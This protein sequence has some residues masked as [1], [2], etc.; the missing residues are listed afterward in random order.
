LT[1]KIVFITGSSRGIGRGIAEAFLREGASVIL[2]GRDPDRLDKT[3][4]MLSSTWGADRVSAIA[5]NV[6]DEKE[7]RGIAAKIADAHGGLDVLVCNA[8]GAGSPPVLKEEAVDW[9]RI[10][11]KNLYS[12]AICIAACHSILS[13]RDGA[14]TVISS[15]AGVEAI[16]APATYASAKAAVNA[17]VKSACRALA[18]EKTRINTICPGNIMFPGSVWDRRMN[19]DHENTIRMLD[20]DVAQHRFGS[21]EDI[22]ATVLF[23]SSPMAGFI[24]GATV[25]V[26][27]GQ[28]RSW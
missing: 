23:L 13:G 1:D 27:G 15:I 22:A 2:N 7:M 24:T 14:I 21:P 4:E 16:G 25:V 10:M 8:G 17:Y 11:E 18:D 5:G 3:H 9:E 28:T 6:A 20:C 12:A 26:D 19:E